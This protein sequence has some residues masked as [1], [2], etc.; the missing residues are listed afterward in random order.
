MAVLECESSEHKIVWHLLTP[1][2]SF[3]LFSNFLGVTL[4]SYVGQRNK[5]EFVAR[6]VMKEYVGWL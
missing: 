6:I 4:I 5:V 3:R 1:R 2:T